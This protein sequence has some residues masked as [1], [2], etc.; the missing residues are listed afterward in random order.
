MATVFDQVLNG[1]KGGLDDLVRSARMPEGP[2]PEVLLQL[3]TAA[4]NP[5]GHQALT[6][7][8]AD[9][10][11]KA[12]PEAS[13]VWWLAIAH[14][15]VDTAAGR[16]QIIQE[17]Q[18]HRRP[19]RPMSLIATEVVV[20]RLR[21][22]R[23][24]PSGRCLAAL[25]GVTWNQ[26]DLLALCGHGL[27][28]QL[29]DR[30]HPCGLRDRMAKAR[31]GLID[32]VERGDLAQ[33]MVLIERSTP[34]P[35]D[36]LWQT[37]EAI[38]LL[39]QSLQVGRA[40]SVASI[41]RLADDFPMAW[42][43]AIEQ[44]F[45]AVAGTP[46]QMRAMVDGAAEV[47]TDLSFSS[48]LEVAVLR[49]AAV[50][51]RVEVMRQAL[52][53]RRAEGRSGWL[54][55]FFTARLL[56]QA[57]N[58]LVSEG[59]DEAAELLSRAI[60]GAARYGQ[61]ERVGLELLMCRELAPVDLFDLGRRSVPQSQGHGSSVRRPAVVQP[62]P[63]ALPDLIG[64]SPAMVRIRE[65]IPDLAAWDVP[66]LLLGAT[67]TGK[68]LLARHLHEAGPRAGR[69]LVGIN[70]AGVSE[71]LLE[72]E[73]FGHVKGSFTGAETSR[74]GLLAA[75]G[76]GTVFLDEIGDASPAFQSSLLRLLECGE[77]RPVGS[78]R[79]VRIEARIIAATNADLEARIQ[80]GRFRA[81][82]LYRLRRIEIELPSLAR[83]RDD[84]PALAQH[85]LQG[86]HPLGTQV[87]CDAGLLAV[88]QSL[89]WPGNIRQ[90]R[91]EVEAL[92]IHSPTVSCYTV[93]ELRAATALRHDAAEQQ[94]RIERAARSSLGDGAV[95]P[96]PGPPSDEPV[97]EEGPP[98]VGLGNPRMRRL[99]ALRQLFLRHRRLT[100]KEAMSL[101]RITSSTASSYLKELCHDG[102]IRR[103]EPTP[104]PGSHYFVLVAAEETTP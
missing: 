76:R 36:A 2:W 49:C 63:S 97:A 9:V 103:V 55:D 30:T 67:G 52:V 7:L 64:S 51:G 56:C 23:T 25:G 13:L 11:A 85:F 44:L 4:Q 22:L 59:R 17:A 91:S 71:Q 88:L 48:L 95:A 27:A 98:Q 18:R 84:I 93:A 83:R 47:G 60:T 69:P 37:Y 87:H 38:L 53:L 35:D 68:D 70:C 33:A 80:Q 14:L 82:L 101:L 61:Q 12:S 46:A 50:L 72:S 96:D 58:R 79:T 100:R 74:P 86:F 39:L 21:R 75:A 104:A 1:A 90:L 15:P 40:L 32:A 28:H 62:A 19:D 16:Q 99:T 6:A 92:V 31:C 10:D 81:D 66:V 5:T 41:R 43:T 57:H 24:G 78:D 20:S 94:R 65:Q 73:L 26:D 54:D 45:M 8:I 77:Y 34:D 42:M 3:V 89:D 29:L 102:F